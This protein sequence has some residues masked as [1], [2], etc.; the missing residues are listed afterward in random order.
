MNMQVVTAQALNFLERGRYG[1][2]TTTRTRMPDRTLHYCS[3][4]K[5]QRGAVSYVMESDLPQ[6]HGVEGSD[7][8]IVS[9]VL[10]D[11]KCEL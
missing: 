5:A 9:L 4:F 10:P 8:K 7:E 11:C 2:K 6:R 1:F 3:G